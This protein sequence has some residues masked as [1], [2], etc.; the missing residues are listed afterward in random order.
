MGELTFAVPPEWDGRRTQDFLRQGCGL[1]WRMVV[2]LRHPPGKITVGGVLRRTIDPVHAGETVVL[3]LPE[4]TLRIPPA[5]LPLAVVYEDDALLVADKPPYLAV[6]PSAGRPEPTLAN[7]AVAHYAAQGVTCSFRPVNRL[8]R[9][10]SGLLLAAKNAHVAYALT[11]KPEKEYLAVVCGA[12]SGTG[13][14]DQPIRLREGSFI[15]REVGEGGKASVTHYA[16]LS[17]DGE[18]TLV[19]LW[20]ETGRTHQIRVHMAWLGHPLAGDDLYG[21]E[22]GEIDRQ[23]LHCAR[24]RFCHPL[25]GEPLD[26][27]APLPEDMR[28]LCANRHLTVPEEYV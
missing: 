20:L 14:V 5:A 16:A 18:R 19:R 7:A 26:L 25:T 17:T 4:D 22:T 9:N 13:T 11:R 24:M 10:T 12:L 8:D 23:A 3:T 21:G 6:H 27:R 28:V 1:S 15:A 2:R